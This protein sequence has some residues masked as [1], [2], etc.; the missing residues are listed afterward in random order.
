ML[1]LT[2]GPE[3]H[4]LEGMF[5]VAPDGREG[6]VREQLAQPAF[7][8]VADLQVRYLPYS[9]LKANR[10]TI[11]RIGHGMN[12]CRPSRGPWS[13]EHGGRRLDQGVAQRARAAPRTAHGY[14]P[15]RPRWAPMVWSMCWQ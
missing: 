8:R 9:E 2:L 10:E 3:A 4:A 5:L 14:G 6:E 7:S 1:D 15:E 13:G 11:A 12:P